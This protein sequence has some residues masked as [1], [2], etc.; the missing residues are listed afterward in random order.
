MTLLINYVMGKVQEVSLSLNKE[1]II[2][3][4]YINGHW[5]ESSNGKT[6]SVVNPAN[7]EVIA[8]VPAGE[9]AEVE[10][11][12]EAA[13]KRNLSAALFISPATTLSG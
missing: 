6:L 3:K 7:E 8:Q 4:N 11:A 5:V 1:F 9:K 2:E 12:A 13:K 10:L